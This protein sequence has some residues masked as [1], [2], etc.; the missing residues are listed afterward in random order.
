MS[1]SVDPGDTNVSLRANV[2]TA[3]SVLP[4]I[5][6]LPVVCVAPASVGL[7]GD[8]S[9]PHPPTASNPTAMTLDASLAFGRQVASDVGVL[10]EAHAADAAHG[11]RF[12]AVL[13][14]DG[15]AEGVIVGR[16]VVLLRRTRSVLTGAVPRRVRARGAGASTIA[17]SPRTTS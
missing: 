6:V 8:P 12:S 11:P 7:L 10:L 1:I 2:S 4:E 13:E 3:T 16:Y 17:R 9:P 14:V 15:V 5:V